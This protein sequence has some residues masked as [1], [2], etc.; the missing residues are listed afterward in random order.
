LLKRIY[1]SLMHRGGAVP[2]ADA[3]PYSDRRSLFDWSEAETFRT[4]NAFEGVVIFGST[5]SGKSSGSGRTLARSMLR[6]GYGGLVLSVKDERAT[7]DRWARESARSEHLVVMRPG[8]EWT[9]NPFEFE[10]RRPGR[11]GGSVENV[12]HLLSTLVG[13]ADRGAAGKGGGRESED[14]WRRAMQEMLRNFAWLLFL[15][16]GS[17]TLDDLCRAINSAPRSLDEVGTEH[18]KSWSFCYEL[19]VEADAKASTLPARREL[20]LVTDYVL[21]LFPGLSD[22]TRSVVVSSFTSMA[23]VLRRGRMHELFGGRSS[24]TPQFSEEGC[25]ILVDLPVLEFGMEGLLSNAIMKHCWCQ[26]IQRRDPLRSRRPVFLYID[27]AHHLVTPEDALFT[28]TCRSARV[29][30]VLITQSV[31]NLRTALGGGEGGRESADALLANLNT[32]VFHANGDATTN[33]FASTLIGKRRQLLMN[34]S[35]STTRQGWAGDALGPSAN[36]QV[37]AGFSEQWDFE[38]RPES[39]PLL[40]NGGEVNQ[41]KVE[42]IVVK[43]GG[44]FRDTGAIWRLAT[45]QQ[46]PRETQAKTKEAADVE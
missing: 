22:R 2:Y 11:G 33:E 20:V 26:S 31:A 41:G 32:R 40:R 21:K 35:D 43:N 42:A 23:D 27:E 39:F 44:A 38:V 36:G 12:I 18:W 45:F 24:V 14:Y 30:T 25:V 46:G 10:L 16:R 28:T 4:A 9:F 17:V 8:G 7:W 5:G 37:S 15:A 29:S 3:D 19:L 34:G 1:R 6:A 13:F